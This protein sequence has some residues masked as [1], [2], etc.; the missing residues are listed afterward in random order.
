LTLDPQPNDHEINGKMMPLEYASPRTA[1]RSNKMPISGIVSFVAATL[2]VPWLFVVMMTA[3]G[4]HAPTG[5]G[6]DSVGMAFYFG[7]ALIPSVVALLLGLYSIWVAGFRLRNIFGIGGLSIVAL[8]IVA[9][10]Y[11]KF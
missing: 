1:R 6:P 4:D 7:V 9:F 5:T 2:Q 8:E 11:G 3:W 10:I